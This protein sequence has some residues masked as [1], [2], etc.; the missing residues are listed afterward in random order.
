MLVSTVA[1]AVKDEASVKL[2]IGVHPTTHVTRKALFAGSTM[3][4]AESGV[5]PTF[6]MLTSWVCGLL[7][8]QTGLTIKSVMR[9]ARQ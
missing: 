7:A 6:V 9:S 8:A 1:P 2:L 4:P 5:P 3:L